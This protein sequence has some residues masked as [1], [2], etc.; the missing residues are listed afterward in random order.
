LLHAAE[1]A[2]SAA[3]SVHFWILVIIFYLRLGFPQPRSWAV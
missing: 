2:N 1:L 3:S